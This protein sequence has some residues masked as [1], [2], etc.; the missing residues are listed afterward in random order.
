MSWNQNLTNL[1]Y[2]LA[3][4]YPFKSDSLPVAKR[5]SLNIINIGFHD[6]PVTNWYYIIDEAVKENKV[7]L[8]IQ[9]AL[10]DYP[11]DLALKGALEGALT[12]IISDIILDKESD[13]KNDA[14][15]DAD[16]YEKIIG[17]EST[18]LDIAYLEI[19]LLCAKSVVR[20]ELPDG[21]TGSGFLI[22]DNFIIT[23][24]H[25]IGNKAVALDAKVQF[26]YQ[27]NAAG[28]DLKVK[29]FELDP[30]NGFATSPKDKHD[31]T[32]IKLKG[33]ANTKWGELILKENS[34]Q[35]NQ[36][37]TII[38]HPNGL[39]KQIALHHN[40]VRYADDNI[41]QY[42]TDTLPGSSGSPVFD[43]QWNLVALHHSGGNIR[44]P[45]TKRI[46]F[47]NEGIHINKV[48]EGLQ[49]NRIIQ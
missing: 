1:N 4:Y 13:W 27:R 47:R 44:E 46:A 33:D 2:L 22:R 48:I 35:K 14:P 41:V 16:T 43:D 49:T 36:R 28:L 20:I 31:W 15:D 19:G 6:K 37:V 21:A 45:G 8:L 34:I 3:G 25:V 23:N 5:A 26:N 17:K 39:H 38:Q 9:A 18:L 12:G 7:E 40:Y 24:N 32:A 10:Q 30:Q 42:L 11:D 29:E